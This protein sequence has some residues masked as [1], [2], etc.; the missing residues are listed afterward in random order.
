MNSVMF[1]SYHWQLLTDLKT[2][3]INS[4]V[5]QRVNR[6]V[7]WGDQRF[8]GQKFTDFHDVSYLLLNL[9]SQDFTATYQKKNSYL[10]TFELWTQKNSPAIVPQK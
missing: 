9:V 5:L 1:T 7:V 8:V 2:S 6:I 4:I 10:L 3:D